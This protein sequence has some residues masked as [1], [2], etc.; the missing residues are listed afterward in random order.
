MG[1]LG[2]SGLASLKSRRANPLSIHAGS[3][4]FAAVTVLLAWPLAKDRSGAWTFCVIFGVLG[5]SIL[6]LP[7][8]GVAHVIPATSR[9]SLG[10]WTGMLWSCCCIPAFVGPVIAG[11]LRDRYSIEAVGYWCGAN[12]IVAGFLSTLAFLASPSKIEGTVD[13]KQLPSESSQASSIYEV[14]YIASREQD[15]SRTSASV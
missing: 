13:T 15:V 6:G 14:D 5:G 3:C 2:S 9:D 1:R 4:F 7:A 8:S 10:T 12:L 11:H